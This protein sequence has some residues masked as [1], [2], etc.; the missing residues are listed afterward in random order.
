MSN[1]SY[2]RF[3]NTDKDLRD[4]E[5]ALEELFS[6]G[7]NNEGDGALSREEL[8]AAV[9]L[10]ETCMRIAER[11]AEEAGLDLDTD[12]AQKGLG[13]LLEGANAFAKKHQDAMRAARGRQ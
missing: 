13:K 5:E 11:V 4:C 10:V 2:C 3:Q 1:M 7:D 9:S 6:G 8:E 12:D